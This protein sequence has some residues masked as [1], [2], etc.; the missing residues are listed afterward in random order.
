MFDMKGI[1]KSLEEKPL[2]SLESANK[3]ECTFFGLTLGVD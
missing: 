1:I 2:L 3:L